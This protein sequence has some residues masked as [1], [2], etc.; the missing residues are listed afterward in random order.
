MDRMRRAGGALST[1]GD[2]SPTAA[3]LLERA[4][5]FERI[6]RRYHSD[7]R[8][9]CA[10]LVG[11]RHRAE[12]LAQETF[13]RAFK[14]LDGF[15]RGRSY[16]P[17]LSTIARRLC[18]D[19]LRSRHIQPTPA[20]NV[21]LEARRSDTSRDSTYDE[22][23]SRLESALLQARLTRALARLDS[24]QRRILQWRAEGRSLREIAGLER[25]TI[26]AVRNTAWRARAMVRE[27]LDAAS[28]GRLAGLALGSVRSL[29]DAAR[30]LRLRLAQLTGSPAAS[31]AGPL[32]DRV[33]LAVAGLVA[34][35]VLF[36]YAGNG[37]GPAAPEAFTSRPPSPS[38]D[39]GPEDAPQTGV[40]TR[41]EAA[42]TQP[43]G[44]EVGIVRTSVTTGKTRDHGAAPSSGYVRVEVAGPSGETLVAYEEEYQCGRNGEDVL[45]DRGPVRVVC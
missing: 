30:R 10:R 41:R 39:G 37:R 36:A 3:P 12:D 29:R 34:A 15:E 11:D 7:I 40:A 6:Y 44:R 32:L 20:E 26:D 38:V 16:W 4:R 14:H 18:V 23:Q 31:E 27:M 13:V 28:E 43:G 24:R 5:T 19:E 21:E 33:G 25:T 35:T 9:L 8:A 45:P 42:A 22:V 17:W 2:A 1:P